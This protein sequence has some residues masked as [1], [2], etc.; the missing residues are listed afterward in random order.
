MY[1]LIYQYINGYIDESLFCNEFYNANDL[2]IN[3][4]DLDKLEKNVFHKLDEIVSRFSPYKEDHL[5][6]P[7]AFYTKKNY[8]R[9]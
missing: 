2:G 5:L 4:N 8:D 7:K 3:H 1:W 6:A 9:K